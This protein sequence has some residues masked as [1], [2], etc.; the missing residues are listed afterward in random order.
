MV[1]RLEGGCGAVDEEWRRVVV[2]RRCRVVDGE[3]GVREVTV[4]VVLASVG[5]GAQRLA[6]DAVGPLH[7]CVGVLVVGRADT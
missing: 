3:L 7:P 6:D 2:E 1:R 5:V 4:Q